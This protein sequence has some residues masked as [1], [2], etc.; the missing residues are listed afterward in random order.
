M[1]RYLF[2]T[3]FITVVGT[4]GTGCFVL[5]V[6]IS[7]GKTSIP[8]GKI[9]FSG[10]FY[11]IDVQRRGYGDSHHIIMVKL[12]WIDTYRAILIPVMGASLGLYLMKQFMEQ[13][14]NA[15]LEAAK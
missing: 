9:Y 7:A 2:N 12:D 5:H 4:A 1:S 13:I 14:N 11:V 3:V 15:F 6:C 8:W 10:Y